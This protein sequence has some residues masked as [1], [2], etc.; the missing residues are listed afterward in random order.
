MVPVCDN[1]GGT[2]RLWQVCGGKV[3]CK[4]CP[5][6]AEKHGPHVMDY[7]FNGLRCYLK[8]GEYITEP[9]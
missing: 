5:C 1:C 8:D 4:D 9:L 7:A 2:E 3:V 6:E